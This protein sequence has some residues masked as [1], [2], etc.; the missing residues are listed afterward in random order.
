MTAGLR[1]LRKAVIYCRNAKTY[2]SFEPKYEHNTIAYQTGNAMTFITDNKLD[3]CGLYVDEM[4]SISS[5]MALNREC[6]AGKIDA[7]IVRDLDVL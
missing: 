6:K 4:D 7:V 3:F 1:E 5:L 2:G